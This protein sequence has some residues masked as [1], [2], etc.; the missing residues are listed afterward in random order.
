MRSLRWRTLQRSGEF[1]IG[2]DQAAPASEHFEQARRLA[3]H[4]DR[5]AEEALS[6][7]SLGVARR[8]AGDLDGAEELIAAAA[9]SLRSLA[10]DAGRCSRR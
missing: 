6:V 5:A 10:G 1:A 7:Y 4:G 2:R 9:Q 8:S 3:R